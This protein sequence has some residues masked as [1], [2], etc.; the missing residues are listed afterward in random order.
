MTISKDR[1]GF[2]PD[3][4]TDRKTVIPEAER[5]QKKAVDILETSWSVP[6]GLD[7]TLKWAEQITDQAVR[8]AAVD[9][10]VARQLWA[11]A[12]RLAPRIKRALSKIPGAEQDIAIDSEEAAEERIRR[13]HVA[14][15]DLIAWVDFVARPTD[16]EDLRRL[17]DPLRDH[18]SAHR[19]ADVKHR[20][21][22]VEVIAALFKD[23]KAKSTA[24]SGVALL[25]LCLAAFV[26]ST[27]FLIARLLGR[28]R[29]SKEKGRGT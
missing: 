6:D 16:S 27:A 19:T 10:V 15:K 20:L 7:L 18:F 8:L 14:A 5:I 12:R 29:S 23:G 4:A 25:L 22:E 13:L 3:W 24:F 26:S 11:I 2:I 17:V 9:Q 28:R 21:R 1:D